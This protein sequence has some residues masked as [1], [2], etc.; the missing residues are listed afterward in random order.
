VAWSEARHIPVVKG[1]GKGMGK[2]TGGVSE[3][4]ASEGEVC[5]GVQEWQRRW[6]MSTGTEVRIGPWLMSGR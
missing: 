5:H 6:L 3:G 1:S 2:R 4:V